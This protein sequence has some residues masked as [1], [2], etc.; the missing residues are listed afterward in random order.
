MN[1]SVAVAGLIAVAVMAAIVVMLIR[2]TN[3]KLKDEYAFSVSAA[4]KNTD[5]RV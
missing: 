1:I 2:N 5:V 4:S 3:N